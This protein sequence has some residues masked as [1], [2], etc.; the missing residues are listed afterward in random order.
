[1]D[2]T[3]EQSPIRASNQIQDRL[4]LTRPPGAYYTGDGGYQRNEALNRQTQP[5]EFAQ[6]GGSHSAMHF[7]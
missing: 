3:D 6:A 2:E 4:E 5:K 7:T 1:M